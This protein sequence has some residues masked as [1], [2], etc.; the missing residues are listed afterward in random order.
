MVAVVALLRG[1]SQLLLWGRMVAWLN[2][3]TPI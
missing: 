1:V 3:S 2:M